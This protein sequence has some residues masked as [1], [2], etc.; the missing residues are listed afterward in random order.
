MYDDCCANVENIGTYLYQSFQLV[1]PIL[2]DLYLAFTFTI[3]WRL[4][5]KIS[6]AN[7]GGVEWMDLDMDMC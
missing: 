7:S 1:V 3:C 2:S 4:R 6:L 5:N